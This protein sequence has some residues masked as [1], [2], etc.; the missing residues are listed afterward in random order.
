VSLYKYRVQG[1]CPSRSR[2]LY[3]SCV[4]I[5]L[6]TWIGLFGPIRPS[7]RTGQTVIP[8]RSD[9]SGAGQVLARTITPHPDSKLDVPHMHFD[10]LDEAYSMVKSNWHFEHN[11]LIGLT[12][13]GERSD[14]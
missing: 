3:R 11:G 13:V 8:H 2:N 5:Q 10:C 9:K 6:L 14:R 12:G 7:S 1:S 4:E